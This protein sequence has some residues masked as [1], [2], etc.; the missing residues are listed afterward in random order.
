MLKTRPRPSALAPLLL[1]GAILPAC[2]SA[3]PAPTAEPAEPIAFPDT[4]TIDNGLVRLGVSPAVGRVVDFGPSGGEDLIWTADVDLYDNPI[5]GQD[6]QRY[7]NLGGDKLWIAPQPL[8]RNATGN[9]NWPPDGV[10]DGSPW[11]LLDHDPDQHTLSIQSPVSPHYGVVVRRDFQLTPGRA[12]AV[13]TNTVRRVEA[14]P[15]PVQVWSVTQIVPPDVAVLDAAA[16]RPAVI[17]P[18]FLMSNDPAKTDGLVDPLGDA[19]N[20]DA[21]AWRQTGDAFAKIG[22]LGR[23]AAAVYDAPD[24]GGLVFRQSTAYDPQGAYPEASSVQVYRASDYIELELLSP[25]VQLTEGEELTNT[26]TWQLRQ[27]GTGGRTAAL[28][29]LLADD[30]R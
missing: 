30:P 4:V 17:D 1:A 24:G 22:S 6:G 19:D 16:D 8:W 28:G 5:L 2:R 23:W 12:E 15:H 27:T 29:A 25:L 11:T 13:V 3:T 18:W 7:F 14:N 20:P 10:I 21:S 9:D 26:V